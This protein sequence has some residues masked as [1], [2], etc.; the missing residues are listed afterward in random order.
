MD[1]EDILIDFM[2]RLLMLPLYPLLADE[3]ESELS[4]NKEEKK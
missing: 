3:V 2:A 1:F 4:E